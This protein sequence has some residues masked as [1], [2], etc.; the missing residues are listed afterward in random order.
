LAQTRY[1]WPPQPPASLWKRW[2]DPA[3]Q[4]VETCTIITTKPNTFG[5]DLLDRL[6]A[7]L[8]PEDYELWL[9]PGITDSRRVVDCLK[10]FDASLMKQYP[11]S[12]R[13]NR[14]ENDDQ[15]CVREIAVSGPTGRL[16]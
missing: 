6:P 10:P 8:R 9:D 5:P 7:M 4:V 2:R 11:V 12:A 1:H 16:F 15:E 3:N 14:P 13:M